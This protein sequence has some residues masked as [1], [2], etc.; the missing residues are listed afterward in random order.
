VDALRKRFVIRVHV[1][2]FMKGDEGEARAV[3]TTRARIGGYFIVMAI[4]ARDVRNGRRRPD[5]LQS[6]T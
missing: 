1:A 6:L 2:R 4:L 3:A 5:L